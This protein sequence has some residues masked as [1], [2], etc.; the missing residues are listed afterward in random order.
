MHARGRAPLL[1]TLDSLTLAPRTSR[2]W[3]ST[4]TQIWTTVCRDPHP[5]MFHSA[6]PWPAHT[7]KNVKSCSVTSSPLTAQDLAKHMQADGASADALREQLDQAAAE[8]AAALKDV[9]Y[10]SAQLQTLLDQ[11]DGRADQ[12]RDCD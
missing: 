12:V 3:P 9:Q 7:R 1:I 10:L 11:Q 5:R 2:T 6:G 8:R 4:C